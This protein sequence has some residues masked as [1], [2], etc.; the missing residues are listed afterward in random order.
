MNEFKPVKITERDRQ[1][2]TIVETREDFARV[3]AR[4]IE[5]ERTFIV[6]PHTD[7]LL[8]DPAMIDPAPEDLS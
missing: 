7:D 8:Y 6:Q 2:V 4:L 5:Q 1:S 3:T